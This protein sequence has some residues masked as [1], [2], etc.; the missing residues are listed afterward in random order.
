RRQP[1]PPTT[2]TLQPLLPHPHHHTRPLTTPNPLSLH[3][4]NL[5]HSSLRPLSPRN[6]RPPNSSPYFPPPQLPTTRPPPPQPPHPT[7]RARAKTS[8]TKTDVPATNT[9]SSPATHPTLQKRLRIGLPHGWQI[10]SGA[11]T[12]DTPT[13]IPSTP[14]RTYVLW[15][16]KSKAVLKK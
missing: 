11:T 14:H 16:T 7:T 3:N 15:D 13:F 9:D 1:P 5:A 2:H 6:R 8:P 12:P 10:A 4:L